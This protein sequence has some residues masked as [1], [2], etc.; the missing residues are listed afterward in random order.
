MF[1]KEIERKFLVDYSKLPDLINFESIIIVQGYLSNI[2][3]NLEVRVRHSKFSNGDKDKYVL[4]IK[5]NGGKVRNEITYNISKDEFDLSIL[6][7]GSKVIR[8]RRFLIPNSHDNT[9]IMEVDFYNDIDL[10]VCEYEAET[11]IMVDTLPLEDWIFKEVT[12]DS[13]YKNSN[14]AYNILEYKKGKD[15]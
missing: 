10:V 12:G 14:I 13:Y 4:E 2:L 1:K 7:C 8:K 9:R 5:D 11:E 6:L 3:D 15:Q